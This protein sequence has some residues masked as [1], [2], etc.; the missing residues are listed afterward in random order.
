M[1]S[2]GSFT[3]NNR[4]FDIWV[5]LI[6]GLLGY[7]L[8]NCGFSLPPIVLGYILASIIESNFRTALIGSRGDFAEI[9]SR[10]IAMGLMIFA[11]IMV[12][13]PLVKMRKKKAAAAK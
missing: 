10:P 9:L 5:L 1:C 12:I 11:V 3:V 8:T 2:L 4:V 7:I 13:W 6:I